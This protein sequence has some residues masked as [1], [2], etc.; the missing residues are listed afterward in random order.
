MDI[1]LIQ[2]ALNVLRAFTDR[3]EPSPADVAALQYRLGS[4]AEGM[5]VDDLARMIIE[6]CVRQSRKTAARA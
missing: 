5:A 4:E 2:T 6:R 3:N 1:E